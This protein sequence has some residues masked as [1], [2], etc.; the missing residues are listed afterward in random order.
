MTKKTQPTNKVAEYSEKRKKT[1]ESE[2]MY[3]NIYIYIIYTLKSKMSILF[4][5]FYCLLKSFNTRG[6][7]RETKK[8]HGRCKYVFENIYIYL[9]IKK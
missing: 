7:I 1:T 5:I 6:T 2:S 8:D 4:I 3:L 9:F